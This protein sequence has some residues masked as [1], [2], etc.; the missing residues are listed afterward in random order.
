MN[1]TM[2]PLATQVTGDSVQNL[3]AH[4]LQAVRD[5]HP[6]MGIAR[7]SGESGRA[8]PTSRPTTC[9]AWPRSSTV[10]PASTLGHSSRPWRS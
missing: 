4:I 10:R 8:R 1:T 3:P 7:N 6:L 5:G 2:T 9:T